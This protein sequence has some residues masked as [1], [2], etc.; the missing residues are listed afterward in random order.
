MNEKDDEGKNGEGRNNEGRN[1]EGRNEETVREKKKKNRSLDSNKC[2]SI[3]EARSEAISRASRIIVIE[4]HYPTYCP[5]S[6]PPYQ[7]SR[8]ISVY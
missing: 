7:I 5:P 3:S 8:K 4:V 6:C 2:G 1:N